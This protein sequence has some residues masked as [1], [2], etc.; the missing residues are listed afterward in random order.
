MQ[1]ETPTHQVPGQS[2]GIIPK[3]DAKRVQRAQKITRSTLIGRFYKA[4]PSMTADDQPSSDKHPLTRRVQQAH[5]AQPVQSRD[6]PTKHTDSKHHAAAQRIVKKHTKASVKRKHLTSYATTAVVVLLLGGYVAYLNIP[7]ISMKVA[8]NRAGFA[9]SMPHAPSGY[10]FSGPIAYSPGQV[11]VSFRSNTDE[12]R[13]SLTQQPTNW[14]SL[15]LLENHVLRQSSDYTTYQDR[16][17]TIYV[18]GSDAAWVSDGKMYTINGQQA[19][20]G[21]DQILGIAASM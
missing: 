2:A 16:G 3:T 17:L 20:L 10:R 1:S 18:H 13:F 6:T 14:D 21:I 5:A 8:A 9:A 15:A 19:R 11:V 4:S 12:R 7:S